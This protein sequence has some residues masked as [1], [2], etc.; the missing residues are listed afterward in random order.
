MEYI[1][2]FNRYCELQR[3][4]DWTDDDALRVRAMARVVEPHVGAM[5]DDFYE[6][7]ARHEETRRVITG[8]PAQIQRLKGTLRD[9]LADILSGDYT[10]DY[11]AKHWRIGRKHVDIGLSQIFVFAALSRL[12]AR[13]NGVIYRES[14]LPAAELACT[15]SSLNKLLDLDLA[16]IEDA[17]DQ[18]HAA[19]KEAAERR[20]SD[21]MFRNVIDAAGCVIVLLREDRTT[22]FLNSFTE[23]LTGMSSRPDEKAF[24]NQFIAESDRD[25]FSEQV[26]RAFAGE[27]IRGYQAGLVIRGGEVR[28]FVWNMRTIDQ[29]ES[30]QVVLAVGQ[31]ISS[32]HEAQAKAL[33]AERLAVIGQMSAGLAHEARNTL[34]RIQACSEMLEFEVTGNSEA[35]DLVRRIQQAQD[36]LHYLFE[37]VRGYAGPVKLDLSELGLREAWREAWQLLAVQRRGR[38]ACLEEE[39]GCDSLLCSADRFRMT[40]VFRN[41]FENA[42]AAC[43]DPVVIRV[44]SEQGVLRDAPA[45]RISVRDNG[46]GMSPEQQRRI[47][48]PFYTTKARG[49]G[50]GMAIAQRIIEAHHG[51][52]QVGNSLNVGAEIVITLPVRNCS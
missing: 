50:L 28:S 47:F 6:E 17:Y 18:E 12:R 51:T 7:L 3:Y 20:R 43:K 4:V 45:L 30:A 39:L 23:E 21:L 1:E 27:F 8:G 32:L 46:P 26:G 36:H 48:E 5:I 19:R 22:A 25:R 49:T 15:L 10:A 38:V 11:V 33:Q 42:M 29:Y 41:L 52:I 24:R 9:W 14:G 35:L 34:Q 37:E 13:L 40:Q 16:L 31:D 2:L 44:Q